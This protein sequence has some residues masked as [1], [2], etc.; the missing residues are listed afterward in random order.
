MPACLQA[1]LDVDQRDLGGMD[2]AVPRGADRV[3]VCGDTV[4]PRG[5]VDFACRSRRPQLRKR[6]ALDLG[7]SC[8]VCNPV[9]THDCSAFGACTAVRSRHA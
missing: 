3:H 4:D 5:G 2:N 7:M 6:F 9:R 8:P 1:A